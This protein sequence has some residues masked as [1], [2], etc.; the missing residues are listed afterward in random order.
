MHLHHVKMYV[1]KG[2]NTCTYLS[3]IILNMSPQPAN[4]LDSAS[5]YQWLLNHGKPGLGYSQDLLL[6]LEIL[7]QWIQDFAGSCLPPLCLLFREERG[8]QE[9]D[10]KNGV[11]VLWVT[12]SAS[13][14]FQQ[15]DKQCCPKTVFPS[16][17]LFD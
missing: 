12:E 5:I 8:K 1:Y 17:T 11:N 10:E 14:H 7:G 4:M 6:L 13:Y 15:T 16:T 3:E 9:R 2:L